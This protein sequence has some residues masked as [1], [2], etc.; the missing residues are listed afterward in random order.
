MMMQAVNQCSSSVH[1]IC[2]QGVL[3]RGESKV[4]ETPEEEGA[5]LSV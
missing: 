5:G 1:R 3:S 4:R 2:V